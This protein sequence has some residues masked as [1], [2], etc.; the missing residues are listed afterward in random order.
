MLLRRFEGLFKHFSVFP[1]LN[2]LLNEL[3]QKLPQVNLNVN[4]SIEMVFN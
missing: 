4:L 1:Y 2:C 3:A